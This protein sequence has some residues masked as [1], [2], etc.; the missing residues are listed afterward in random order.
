MVRSI[1][2]VCVQCIALQVKYY[3]QD[4]KVEKFIPS[5]C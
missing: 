1:Y 4:Y 3:K 5:S 2:Y